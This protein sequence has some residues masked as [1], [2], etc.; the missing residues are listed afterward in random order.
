MVDTYI[1]VMLFTA[2]LILAGVDHNDSW[3]EAIIAVLLVLIWP[4]VLGFM[5]GHYLKEKEKEKKNKSE[6]TR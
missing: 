6:V 4:I 3:S 5:V 1:I 2:G